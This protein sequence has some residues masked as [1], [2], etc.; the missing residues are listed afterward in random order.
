MVRI[1]DIFCTL[2][3][4]RSI[5]AGLRAVPA[6]LKFCAIQQR[7][8][9]TGAPA[10]RTTR[11]NT[12]A[13]VRHRIFQALAATWQECGMILNIQS[14]HVMAFKSRAA[15]GRQGETISALN[16]NTVHQRTASRHRGQIASHGQ[17]RNK[18]KKSMY[19]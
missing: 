5:H 19:V 4:K 14:C 18:E 3:G 17:G 13:N 9:S 8:L 12:A 16:S 6:L 2:S 1:V 11:R 10:L 7:K 15:R